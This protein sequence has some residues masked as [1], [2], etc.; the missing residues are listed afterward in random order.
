MIIN[1][2]QSTG[3]RFQFFMSKVDPVT[4]E[5]TYDTPA[6]DAFVTIRGKEPF[7]KKLMASRK[8][9]KPEHVH[10]KATR[11][12]QRIRP[13]FEDQTM[14]EVQRDTEDSWDYAIVDFEGFKDQHGNVIE[15]NRQNK[16]LMV[17][18]PMFLRF[19]ERCLELIAENSIK[20]KEVI[21]KNSLPGPSSKTPRLKE[22]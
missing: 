2:D 7:Y 8:P 14:A 21:G 5:I 6:G 4:K 10:D 18:N 3:E 19:A 17:D 9:G 1:L 13:L 20:E 12:L 16:L 15:C 11:Q 22:A